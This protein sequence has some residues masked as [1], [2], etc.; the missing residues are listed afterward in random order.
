MNEISVLLP[1]AATSDPDGLCRAHH[2]IVEQTTAPA[3]V[4]LVTNQPLTEGIESAISDLTDS[5]SISHHEQFPGT[6]GL[7][8]VLRAGLNRCTEPFVARMDADDIADPE[9]F[10]EQLVVLTETE[11]DIVGSHLAEFRDDPETTERTRRVPTSHDEIAEWM[12]WRCPMNH[13]TTMFDREAVIDV[14]GYREFPMMEDWDLW[15]RCLD[16]GLRFQNLDRTLVRAEVGELAD[17][18]SGVDYAKAEVRMAGELQRLG[19]A[20]RRDT[21]Q[22][23]CL[24]V[25]P[26]VLH[27]S[28]FRT[29]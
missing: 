25:P 10:A 13:P 11:T 17:R 19:I 2:S 16:A 8:G 15:A 27:K 28:T 9:R 22:H 21:L 24:R 20:S 14:G 29:R 5:H 7:G 4:L 6:Q 12:S 1:V 23:L 18:R 26:R 3:E